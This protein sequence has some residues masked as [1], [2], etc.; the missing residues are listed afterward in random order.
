M[1]FDK[2]FGILEGENNH[3]VTP[4]DR[5]TYLEGKEPSRL[6]F[7]RT[8]S[9]NCAVRKA[10]PANYKNCEGEK[11]RA[12]YATDGETDRAIEMIREE[13]DSKDPFFLY[14]AYRAPHLPLQAPDE[15]V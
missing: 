7:D 11:T 10:G 5:S 1:G 14:L 8:Y 4:E 9:M 3:F 6:S 2:Y 15:L 13:H 12:F